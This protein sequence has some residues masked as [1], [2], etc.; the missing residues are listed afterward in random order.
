MEGRLF[1]AVQTAGIFKDSK[2]FVDAVPKGDPERILKLY[3][4]FRQDDAF[5]L[6]AFVREHFTL[7]AAA[8]APDG[9]VPPLDTGS[10][11]AYIGSLWPRLERA[12]EE[13]PPG[14]TLIALTHPYIVPGGRFREIYYWDS[15]FTFLGLVETGRLDLVESAVHNLVDLQTRLGLIPN[16]NRH[17]FTTR[18]QPPVLSLMVRL[19]WDERYRDAEDGIARTADLVRALRAEHAF[20]SSPT[21]AVKLP[22]GTVLSRYWDSATTPRPEAYAED[23]ALAQQQRNPADLYT[24]LRAAAESGWDFSSRWLKD[25]AKLASIRTSDILP[26]DLNCLLYELEQSLVGYLG[27]LGEADKSAEFA[28]AAAARKNAIQT[29]CWDEARGFYFDYHWRSGSAT[30]V[31]S[32]AGVLPLFTRTATPEQAAKVKTKLMED[33]LKPG[34]LVTTL[35][36]SGQQWDAPNGWAP[37]HW[38]AVC[39]LQNYGFEAEAKE[40]ATRWLATVRRN[41]DRDKKLLEKYDV[42]NP[43]KRAAGGEYEVQ[44]GFGWTNGVTLKLLKLYG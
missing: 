29:K 19:L 10:L 41:F 24:H 25:P 8:Q 20:W 4:S 36:A 7:P 6:E 32:L 22:D 17:Y 14:G 15:Y 43:D 34:G 35:H 31:Y 27:L 5:S 12:A 21:R 26:V 3:E 28:A 39:G 16:G 40:I 1:R 13:A 42:V 38:F 11:E 44:E 18:S 23:R 2:T 30:D 37:L 9:D 33:F